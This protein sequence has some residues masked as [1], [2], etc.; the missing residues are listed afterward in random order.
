[1]CPVVAFTA[2]AEVVK[3]ATLLPARFTVPS[4]V[5]PSLKV[6]VP[7]VGAMAEL[8]VAV[9]VTGWPNAELPGTDETSEIVVGA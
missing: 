3:L 2:R 7:L 6:T 4:V 1:M 9:K 8:I 5:A